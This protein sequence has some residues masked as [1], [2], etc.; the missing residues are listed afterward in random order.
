M[1]IPKS[2]RRKPSKVA[3]LLIDVINALDFEGSESLLA[4]ATQAAPNIE[5]LARRARKAKVPVIY[6]NDNFGQWR[7]SFEATIEACTRPSKP[8]RHVTFRLRPRRGDYF[9]LKP[10][11]SGFFST[12]LRLLLDHLRVSTLILTGFATNLCVVFTANDAHML[13][14]HLHV[15]D[16]CTASNSPRLTARAL[17]HVRDGL[18]ADTTPSEELDLLTLGHPRK[19]RRAQGI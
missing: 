19:R 11:H 15:P 2:S 4:A 1:A 18:G 3:L 8:G 6:V 5:Q 12:P 17:E 10:R 14:Y 13:G 7:S 16:D 9:V